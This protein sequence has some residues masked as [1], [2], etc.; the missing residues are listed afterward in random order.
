MSQVRVSS[1]SLRAKWN[2]FDRANS[3]AREYLNLS[4]KMIAVGEFLLAYDVAKTGLSYH[5][6]DV[7]LCQ[8]AAHALCKAGS[9][10]LASEML[11]NLVACGDRGVE[12]QSLLASA[13]KDLWEQATDHNSKLKYAEL[14]IARYSEGFNQNSFE[15]LRASQRSELETQY[16]PC[17]NISFMHFFSDKLEDAKIYAEKAL[18]ICEKL[19]SQGKNDYWIQATKSEAY[20]INGFIEESVSSYVE[21]VSM[22]DSR[23][24]W[25]SSTRKQA[26]QIASKYN[27]E[28]I[29]N[30]VKN[31]FPTLGIIACSG[32]VIDRPGSDPR[33]PPEAELIAKEEITKV[34]ENLNTN[35]GY[36]SAAC[37][38]DIIFLEAM[39]ER[40]AETHVFLPFCKKDFIET[41][42]RRAGGNWVARF[43]RVLDRATSIHYVTKEG[44]YGDNDLFSFCND[45]LLG[46]AVMRGRGLDEDP[47]LMVLWD[48]KPGS[49][50][51]TGEVVQLWKQNFNQP[52]I[53]DANKVLDMIP[54]RQ[55]PKSHNGET[56][57][58]ISVSTDSILP[59]SIKTMLFAD[60]EGFSG[61]E[62]SK[63]PEFLDRFLDGVSKILDKLS[64]SP[65]FVNTWGDSFFAVFEE[66]DDG[67]KLA[68]ELRDHFASTDWS[69]LGFRDGIDVR[70]SMHAGPVFE[71]FDPI[72]KKINFFG[73]HVNQAA[74]IEPIVLPGSV[75]VSETVAAKLSLGYNEF[76]FEY[77]GNLELAKNYG[78][79][80]L[81]SLQRRG[82]KYEN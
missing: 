1:P 2:F 12:T 63:L 35:C 8:T 7:K 70:I 82:Y 25:I 42:V 3:S 28:G 73:A 80:P 60:I 51:G 33:F 77:V 9:P 56:R 36:S 41:S 37:G 50:G 21:A 49:K 57:P 71:K 34:L 67:L 76:D 61:V 23:P 78:N 20:L 74:R 30:I 38:T 4:E 29:V 19:Q 27:D 22:T 13:Y 18:R 5:G 55:V 46:F 79:Y 69:D 66:L 14:T 31:A 58:A 10:K 54:D 40:G 32:H 62:D 64:L 65:T 39:F 43:E 24:S 68:L 44:Y 17:I 81:Y 53:I 26:L 16:Y 52:T 6:N 59:R 15:N 72:L 11:E 75:F 48:G 47:N 45:V